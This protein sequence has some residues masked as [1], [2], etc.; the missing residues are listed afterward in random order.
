MTAQTAPLL[1]RAASVVRNI[2]IEYAPRGVVMQQAVL[3]VA[4]CDNP[5]SR[6]RALT[7]ATGIDRS[8]ISTMLKRMQHLGWITMERNDEDERSVT[9]E[10][11]T[12]GRKMCKI[13]RTALDQTNGEITMRLREVK[14]SVLGSAL[15]EIVGVSDA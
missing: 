3:L 1:L 7:T 4:V 12:Q 6:Q 10:A 14:Q 13:L 11:T 2:F 5:W 9:I 15:Q 8:S